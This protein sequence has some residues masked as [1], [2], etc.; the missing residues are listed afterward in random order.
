M[1]VLYVSF[2]SNEVENKNEFEFEFE[3]IHF[4]SGALDP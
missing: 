2:A 4:Y 3:F 1:Y